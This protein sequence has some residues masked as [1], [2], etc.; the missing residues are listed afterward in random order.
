MDPTYAP[1]GKQ[2]RREIASTV[3]EVS[4]YVLM[5]EIVEKLKCLNYEQL[6]IRKN[7]LRP[8]NAL[9]FAYPAHNPQ[10]QFFILHLLMHW[11]AEI[12]GQPFATQ[13]S[14][15]DDPH[16]SA[17]AMAGQLRKI[18]Y[19]TEVAPSELK[20]GY[21]E[22][23]CS[24]LNFLCDLALSQRNFQVE[25]PQFPDDSQQEEVVEE[26][27][28]EDDD[29]D[30]D[31]PDEDV[32]EDDEDAMSSMPST[33]LEGDDGITGKQ[34]PG[35]KKNHFGF[36]DDEDDEEEAAS[37]AA[38]LFAKRGSG[39]SA[40]SKQLFGLD[41]GAKID[42]RLGGIGDQTRSSNRSSHLPFAP[43]S[44]FDSE[45][46][47]IEAE[48]VAPQLKTRRSLNLAAKDWFGHL[49][50]TKEQLRQLAE[51]RRLVVVELAVVVR[52][53]QDEMEKIE[54]RER[55][56]N[57]D[58]RELLEEYKTVATELKMASEEVGSASKEVEEQAAMLASLTDQV[59]AAKNDMETYS[60]D[61]TNTQPLMKLKG[62]M[63]TLNEELKQINVRIGTL[64]HYLL[65][66]RQADLEEKKSTQQRP[67][68]KHSS[69]SV[70]PNSD[71]DTDSS[72]Y[73]Y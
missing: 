56:F 2:R 64:Q 4:S 35:K 11:L 40:L 50:E 53:V 25:Q 9:Y 29:E 3:E 70:V 38:D 10:E 39:M 45:Q 66:T 58:C 21:G 67:L 15:D 59:E 62:A 42:G 73:D 14:I 34:K 23:V 65:Q 7:S 5:G 43:K 55:F 37:D 69:P 6:F 54:K 30:V 24:A 1:T 13:A 17:T 52:E 32:M 48:R 60:N 33:Y 49:E 28:G 57:T 27:K 51:A 22:A 41:S 18:G 8:I 63:N 12:A 44:R 47:K 36:G 19:S 71:E 46:W 61:V 16:K 68:S 20:K 26:D 72:D 31:I